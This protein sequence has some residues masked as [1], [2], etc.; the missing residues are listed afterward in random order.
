[1]KKRKL[2][3]DLEP[4]IHERKK[5]VGIVQGL[6]IY[7]IMRKVKCRIGQD[8]KERLIKHSLSAKER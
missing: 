6:T 8:S 1:M 5:K 3:K 2:N 4:M 7:K